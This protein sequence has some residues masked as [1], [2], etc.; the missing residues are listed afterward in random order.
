MVRLQLARAYPEAQLHLVVDNYVVHKTPEV[1]ACLAEN[2]RFRVHFTP[3]SASWL[4][5]VEVW[6]GIV[7]RE[8]QHRVDVASVLE[9]NKKI[10]ALVTGWNDCCHPFV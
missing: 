7:E 4:I 6:F 1:R 8:A 9:L 3:T 5:F 10:W 2:P